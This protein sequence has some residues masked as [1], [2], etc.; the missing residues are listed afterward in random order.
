[1]DS[2]EYSLAVLK[3]EGLRI[4]PQRT[5]ILKLLSGGRSKVSVQQ[6]YSEIKKQHPGISLDTVYRTLGTLSKLGLVSQINMQGGDLLYEFQ[7][8]SHHHHAICIGCGHSFC[9]DDCPL[10]AEFFQNLE[11]RNFRVQS[12]AFEVY[13][14]CDKCQERAHA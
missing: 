10:P 7:G 12:H 5:D 1:M 3:R 4:T 2:L 6:V 9:L 8:Q 14:Y 13:G 11:R